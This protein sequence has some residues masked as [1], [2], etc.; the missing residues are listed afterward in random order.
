MDHNDMERKYIEQLVAR[1][2]QEI[3]LFLSGGTSLSRLREIV[4]ASAD[5]MDNSVPPDVRNAS[6][7]LANDLEAVI[8][9][10]S[11]LDQHDRSLESIDAWRRVIS[12]RTLRDISDTAS[13]S[14]EVRERTS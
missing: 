13:S 14:P 10:A 5:A 12:T 3:E 4:E 1:V 11:K 8:Y 6:R 9:T 2:E 7:V